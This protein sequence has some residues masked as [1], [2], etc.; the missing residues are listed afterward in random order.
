MRQATSLL[1]AFLLAGCNGGGSPDSDLLPSGDDPRDLCLNSQCGSPRQLVDLPDL[2]NVL[3][4][5]A[6][7]V[8]VTGQQGLYEIHR[9]ADGSYRATT[10]S[11]GC[12]GIMQRESWVYA[13]CTDA[14][15]ASAVMV[16]DA[17]AAEPVPESIFT[18]AGMTLP[19]G[20]AA[21]PEHTLFVTDGP[22][23]VEPKIV[24]LQLDP[25][26]PRVV[27]AQDTWLATRPDYPNG[28]AIRGKQLYTTL[29]NPTTAEGE[30][31]R[32]DIRAGGSAGPI[33]RIHTRGI[34]D[35][36]EVA[37]DTLLVTDWQS[38]RLFQIEFDGALVQETDALSYSQPSSLAVAPAAWFDPPAVLVTERYTGRGLWVH[39]RD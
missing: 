31:A 33:E 7:R 27:L 28:L 8:F 35:D 34:M 36:L 19:N 12:S 17:N 14:A 24:R 25:A 16:F 10:L 4:T 3:V 20:L 26:N 15:G 21:G 1:A 18:L 13:L 5:D 39:E 9:N 11:G 23:A 2:E 37:G 6:G 22:I 30:V 29:F 32:I 38:N